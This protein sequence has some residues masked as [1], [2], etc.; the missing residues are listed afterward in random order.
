MQDHELPAMDEVAIHITEVLETERRWVQAHRELNIA[1]IEDILDEAYKRI[2]EDGSVTGKSDV[3]ASYRSGERHWDVA[4]GS[5]YA[6]QVFENTAVVAGIRRGVGVNQGQ[7]FDYRARSITVYVRCM[8]G[9]EVVS[10][11]VVC[12]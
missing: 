2:E 1:D 8:D 4:E 10:G 9:L 12:A 6:V 3:V 5:D 11:R 7:A